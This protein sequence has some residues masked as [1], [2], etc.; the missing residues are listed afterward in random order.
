MSIVIY[1]SNQDVKAVVGTEKGGQAT[2]TRI[3]RA[4]APE[5]SIINGLV[6]NE[7]AFTEFLQEFW[8]SSQLPKKGVTLVLGSAQVVTRLIEVPKMSHKKMMEYLPREFASVERSRE[9]VYSYL[10]L[11][12]AGAMCKVLAT[13]VDRSFLEPH[14]QR[15]AELGIG[16]DG[17]VMATMAEIQ[18][19][20]QLSYVRDKTCMIQ[21]LDGMSLLN[22]LYVKGEYYQFSRSRV[23]GER[24]SV[25]FG[26]E[27]AR[28][29]SNQQQ[30]L[31]SQQVEEE[32][33]HIYLG[34][35]FE[36][37]DFEVCRDSI[38]QM[39]A[40]LE[41]EKIYEEPGSIL[42]LMAEPDCGRFENFVTMIGGLLIPK[43]RSNLLFQYNQNPEREKQRRDM[44]LHLAPTVAAL[45]VLGIVAA[46]QGF[47]WFSRAGEINEQLDY[48]GNPEVIMRVAEY[49][50]LVAEQDI[51]G[52]RLGIIQNTREN[53]DS[54]PLY[55]THVK[56]A[57]QS[58]AAGFAS[59]DIASYEAVTGTVSLEAS[60]GD[61]ERIHQF[62]DRLENRTDIFAGI[63]YDGF[64]YDERSNVWKASVACYLAAPVQE[65]GE[66]EP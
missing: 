8:E 13:M 56:E 36:D 17:I 10:I 50:G 43:G 11:S 29:I 2:A 66:V 12:R 3:C 52:T 47:L 23:F 65:D 57:V 46:A 30:F 15:F 16:L 51:L 22:I 34:G 9:P 31:K 53:L 45:L 59:V 19:F 32:I 26:V 54:Y 20:N 60:S 48:M 1:L 58:C 4:R 41:V 39:D 44:I 24:G 25:T 55:T 37:G 62:V 63:Y 18:A 28:A 27:C 21:M 6:T 42:R 40:D 38:A 7:E 5:G 61:A 49:D 64:S 33:T 14:V 35:E